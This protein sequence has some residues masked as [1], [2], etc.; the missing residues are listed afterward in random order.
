M[1]TLE[2][3]IAALEAELAEYAALP[4]AGRAQWKEVITAARNNLTEL[5]RAQNTAASSA[6]STEARGKHLP[7][8]LT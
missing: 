1:S 4:L 8:S 2:D 3:K 6:S 5:L 7:P